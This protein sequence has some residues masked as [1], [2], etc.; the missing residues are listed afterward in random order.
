MC[1]FE[2]GSLK[3]SYIVSIESIAVVSALSNNVQIVTVLVL[4]FIS[5]QFHICFNQEGDYI[6]VGMNLSWNELQ[7]QG[8]MKLLKWPSQ[9]R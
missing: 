1:K 6:W 8:E 9:T 4:V 2:F 3:E 7:P 5:N